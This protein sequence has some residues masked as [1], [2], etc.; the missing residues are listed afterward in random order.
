MGGLC[1]RLKSK[2]IFFLESTSRRSMKLGGRNKNILLRAIMIF[3]GIFFSL[4]RKREREREVFLFLR[5]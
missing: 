1:M 5:S 3:S 4:E 2:K